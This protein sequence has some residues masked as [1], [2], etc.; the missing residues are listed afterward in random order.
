MS[1]IGRYYVRREPL[2][3][4]PGDVVVLKG[5]TVEAVVGGGTRDLVVIESAEFGAVPAGWDSRSVTLTAEE[6]VEEYRPQ[7]DAERAT[8][9]LEQ[10]ANAKAATEALSADKDR[11]SPWAYYDTRLHDLAKRG[12]S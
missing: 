10:A 11:V 7:T 3:G 1:P 8:F 6:L 12:R 9:A 5:A 2:G 4:D